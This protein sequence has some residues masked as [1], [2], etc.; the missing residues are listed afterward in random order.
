MNERLKLLATMASGIYAGALAS[1]Q[2]SGSRD[3]RY[4]AIDQAESI[5]AEIERRHPRVKPEPTG[6]PGPGESLD[7]RRS[8][9]IGR[10]RARDG[11]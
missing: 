8:V 1:G 5:L 9:V 10:M 11:Q 3:D 6:I 2:V 4:T 7:A